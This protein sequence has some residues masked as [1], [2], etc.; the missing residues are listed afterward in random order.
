MLVEP[1]VWSETPNPGQ[2]KALFTFAT[3]LF[4]LNGFDPQCW[5]KLSHASSASQFNLF[6]VLRAL[7]SE[8]LN[9][10][11][12]RISK[13]LLANL[14]SGGEIIYFLY[15]KIKQVRTIPKPITISYKV[16]N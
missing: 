13:I 5:H 2:S 10:F 1:A 7:F 4:T 12:P 16:K 11:A 3:K 9:M 6:I 14:S 8:F 15:N